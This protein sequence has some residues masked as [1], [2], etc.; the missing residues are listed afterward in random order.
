MLLVSGP[1]QA[2]I[3]NVLD[4]QARIQNLPEGGAGE[5]REEPNLYQRGGLGLPPRSRH[6]SS[7]YIRAQN[8]TKLCENDY[9]YNLQN[10]GNSKWHYQQK[11]FI[12]AETL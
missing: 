5:R 4:W 2:R 1:I 6:V 10:Y 8:D 3:Q 7:V 12:S 11:S 9:T